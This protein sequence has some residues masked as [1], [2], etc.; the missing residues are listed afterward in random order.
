MINRQLDRYL[1]VTAAEIQAVAAEV[2]PAGQPGRA[3]L[4]AGAGRPRPAHHEE[5]AA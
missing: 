2:L 5:T 4:H 3:D 1:A